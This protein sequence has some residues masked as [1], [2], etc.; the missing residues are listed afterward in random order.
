MR[1][2]PPRQSGWTCICG[3]WN[4]SSRIRCR[5]CQSPSSE[6]VPFHFPATGQPV[7]AVTV[8]GQP[9]IFAADVCAVLDIAN[10]GNALARL[11][12]DEKGSIRL[13][14]G[15][16]GNPNRAIVSEAGFYSLV[17]RSDKPEAKTFRRWVTH[18]VLPAL[19]R[20]GTYSVAPVLGDPLDELERQMQMTAQ[21][22]AIAKAE[23]ER[24]DALEPDA[25]RARRTLD[26]DGLVLVGT[27]AKR[28]GIK[29]KAL[30]EFLFA[31]QLLIRTGTR[32]NEPYARYVE[33]GHFELKT[34]LIEIDPDRAPEE[35]STTYVTPKGEALI[36]RRL[37]AAGLVS[38]PTMPGEQLAIAG[39]A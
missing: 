32:R 3:T 23:R 12:A 16:S 36:W 26:A 17:I 11:D 2:T 22:I 4:E 20:T 31:E 33:S 19:R 1:P 6:I 21:A 39:G 25:A 13:T 5:N 34:R 14:D 35:R 24:A 15:T 37:H 30:R 27:V 18:E 9:W 28:F 38:S 8:D 10:V 7:R 29:E